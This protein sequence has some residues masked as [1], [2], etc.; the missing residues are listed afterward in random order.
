MSEITSAQYFGPYVN[1]PDATAEIRYHAVGLL[2]VVNDMLEH[3][4]ADGV[5]FQPNPHTGCSVS[6]NGNGGFRPRDCT[7]G[8]DNSQHKN[9]RAVDVYDPQRQFA[10]WCMAHPTEMAKRNLHMEDPR[11]TPSWV[12]LQDVPPNSGRLVFIPSM[13]PALAK[14]PPVWGTTGGTVA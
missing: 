2:D 14:A 11:W 8:A 13:S 9:G 1:H 6:G 12:H 10:S 4:A 5:D 3:A 7:V